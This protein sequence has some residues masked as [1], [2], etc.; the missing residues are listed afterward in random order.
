M[1]CCHPGGGR[2]L[3]LRNAF[4]SLTPAFLGGRPRPGSCGPRAPSAMDSFKA[5]GAHFLSAAAGSEDIAR[6]SSPRGLRSSLFLRDPGVSCIF[7]PFSGKNSFHSRINAFDCHT[8]GM[9]TEAACARNLRCRLS[10]T[11]FC[12]WEFSQWGW[13]QISSI[14]SITVGTQGEKNPFSQRSRAE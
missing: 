3:Q 6:L 9:L 5:T 10:Q 11:Q 7:F 12:P 2:W 13:R 14:V 4:W 1:R 8:R